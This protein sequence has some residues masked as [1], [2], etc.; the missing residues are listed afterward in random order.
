MYRVRRRFC[1]KVDSK[2][3]HIAVGGV[4]DE[5]CACQRSCIPCSP[6]V[7]RASGHGIGSV[8]HQG[9][10]PLP[11]QDLTSHSGMAPLGTI[12]DADS[13]VLGPTGNDALTG[14]RFDHPRGEA[15]TIAPS[16]PHPQVLDQRRPTLARADQHQP[17]VDQDWP[18]VYRTGPDFGPHSPDI[19]YARPEFGQPRSTKPNI[20]QILARNRRK[21]ARRCP[22]LVRV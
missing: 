15:P 6:R 10:T 13:D 17:R 11:I 18:G 21:M 7:F 3:S 22:T 1:A 4:I 9:V 2:S 19:G 20:S 12:S 8:G 14:A 5:S 16:E